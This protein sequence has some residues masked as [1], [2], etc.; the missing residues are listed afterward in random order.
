MTPIRNMACTI[1]CC[2]KGNICRKV[3]CAVDNNAAP[4][5]PWMIRHATNSTRLCEVP[6][7]NEAVMNSRIEKPRYRFLPKR[8][9]RN[10]VIGKTTTFDKIYPVDTHPIS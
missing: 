7:K 3:A 6:Q 5:A 9:A 1:P 8:A 2:S 10:A 4:P